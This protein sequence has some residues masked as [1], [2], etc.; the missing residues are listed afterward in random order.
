MHRRG[1]EFELQRLID[2][3]NF[4]DVNGY[5]MIGR[6]PKI[7][8][9]M[10]KDI[11][12][13]IFKNTPIKTLYDDKGE[14]IYYRTTGGRYFKV[15]TNYPTGSTKEKPLYF[16]NEYRMLLVAFLAVLW[17]FGFTK[18]IPTILTGRHMR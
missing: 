9:K 5:T 15:V 4:V 18:S 1:N 16:Q 17:H 2:N 10:E 3:L 7:G 6:I 13:K 8:S 11:L 14:P 12:T